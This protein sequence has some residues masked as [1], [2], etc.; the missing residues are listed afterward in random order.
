MP[1]HRYDRPNHNGASIY[2]ATFQYNSSC[3]LANRPLWSFICTSLPPWSRGPSNQSNPIFIFPKQTKFGF[4]IILCV[5][6]VRTVRVGF[7]A[8]RENR[9][10]RQRKAKDREIPR[11]HLERIQNFGFFFSDLHQ[12][13]SCSLRPSHWLS[14]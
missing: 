2:K 14:L 11:S 7:S 1:L 13:L 10:P 12:C 4:Y 5:W 8:F 6:W 3:C 9:L